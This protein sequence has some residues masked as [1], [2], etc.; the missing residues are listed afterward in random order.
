MM[1]LQPALDRALNAGAYRCLTLLRSL[2]G[3]ARTLDTL[4]C[5]IA[6]QMGKCTNT[7]RT[8]RDQLVAAGYVWWTTNRRTG[9]TRVLILD[10]VEPVER[11]AGQE[12]AAWPKL[13][14]PANWRGGAQFSAL[15][16]S[17]K[18]VRA[19]QSLVDNLRRKPGALA[20]APTHTPEEY[21][22]IVLSWQVDAKAQTK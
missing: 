5:S 1:A 13:P 2:S 10:P 6:R 11:T 17:G 18:K 14:S 12:R 8:Y 21:L 7:I 4:T 9:I 16:N 22:A 19:F 3:R 20:Q 15:I